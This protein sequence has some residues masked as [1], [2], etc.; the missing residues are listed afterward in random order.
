MT[1]QDLAMMCQSAHLNDQ[2][3]PL[4]TT[5]LL[6][7]SAASVSCM[8]FRSQLLELKTHSKGWGVLFGWLAWLWLVWLVMEIIA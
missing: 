7:P 6:F 8:S 5:P 3:L 1:Q 4:R 2:R